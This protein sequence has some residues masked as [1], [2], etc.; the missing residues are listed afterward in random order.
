MN[1]KYISRISTL[2]FISIILFSCKQVEEKKAETKPM[3]LVKI[4]KIE[5]KDFKHEI[6]AQGDL[7]CKKESFLNPEIGGLVSTIHVK[8]GDRVSA[9]QLLIS[10]DTELLNLG[11][12]ELETQL[13]FAKFMLNK[14]SEL[15]EKGLGTEMEYETSINQVATL[16]AKKRSISAQI[17]KASIIAPFAG[18]INKINTEKGQMIG[19]QVPVIH[20]IN[21][22]EMDLI[23]GVSEKHLK[24]IKPGTKIQV[25]FPNFT[26]TTLQLEVEQTGKNIHATNRTFEIKTSIKNN[27]IFLSNMLAEVSITDLFVPNGLVIP[28]NSI[29]KSPNNVDFVF[30]AIKKGNKKYSVK[31]V[32]IEVIEKY[33]GE[34]LIKENPEITDQTM[35]VI[36]GARGISS[37]DIVRID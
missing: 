25:T 6:T 30:I 1:T 8:E 33:N 11:L 3:S 22:S 31:E 9:G 14:Q 37:K 32:Q 34:T 7:K 17:K 36:E 27:S 2:V 12:N 18:V 5:R 26:D 20:L 13:E 4:K 15:K 19:P 28:S 23:A 29:M 24:K 35:I 10:I 21:N 16:N